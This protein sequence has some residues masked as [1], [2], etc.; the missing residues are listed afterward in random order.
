MWFDCRPF[1]QRT[2]PMKLSATEAALLNDRERKMVRST[3]PWHVADLVSLI[4][5]LR[6]LRDKQR[7]LEQRQR[8]RS[9]RTTGS[10]GGRSGAANAR[11][12]DK[13]QLLD[14]ALKHFEAE[15][16]ALDRDSSSAVRALGA[17]ATKKPAKK[18]AK[19]TAKKAA[20]KT[21]AAKRAPAAAKAPRKAPSAAAGAKKRV[22]KKAARKGPSKTVSAKTRIDIPRS[23]GGAAAR[24]RVGQASRRTRARKAR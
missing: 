10:K 13:G 4:R 9:A 3:G 7:D 18:A 12:G 1:L 22:A 8:L 23:L 14:R 5:R 21:G 20:K 15:L 6:D 11:T 2:S 19:K 17:Q 24:Q 16:A